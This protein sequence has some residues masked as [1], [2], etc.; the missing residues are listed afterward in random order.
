MV[1]NN[2]LSCS[3]PF[4]YYYSLGRLSRINE[5]PLCILTCHFTVAD[6]ALRIQTSTETSY[7]N[8]LDLNSSL[9][10]TKDCLIHFTISYEVTSSQGS[11]YSPSW[12]ANYLYHTNIHRMPKGG[13]HCS[14]FK[15]HEHASSNICPVVRFLSMPFRS[16]T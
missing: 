5:I 13:G 9:Q 6:K 16:H 3:V 12:K 15:K 10:S 11:H 1:T 7:Y 14:L 4:F 2:P 8:A